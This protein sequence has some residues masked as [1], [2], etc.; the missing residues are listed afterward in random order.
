MLGSL[1]A[2]C[3]RACGEPLALLGTKKGQFPITG[4]DGAAQRLGVT[5]TAT[6]ASIEAYEP[7]LAN[8]RRHAGVF[9]PIRRADFFP[10]EFFQE[11]DVALLNI[12]DPRD[13]M[14]SG[15]YGFL[16]LH[17]KG[18]EEEGKKRKW[19]AGIESYVLNDMVDRFI[20]ACQDYIDLI[21]KV[22][23]MQV[24]RYEEM[25]TDFPAWFGKYYAAMKLDPAKF[26]ECLEREKAF[27]VV[28]EEED[29]DSHKRQMTP[30]DHR[31]KLGE[32]VIAEI[33]RRMEPQLRYFGYL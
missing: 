12:R 16:R 31:R 15:Y 9:A 27:F 17:G 30:G 8:W 24:L 14:V 32:D 19:D 4:P 3:A 10:P 2:R 20:H 1:S 7:R 29:I 33:D 18:L 13:C 28:P 11:G 6:G 22:P 21:G 5:K 26:D 23:A 25:V